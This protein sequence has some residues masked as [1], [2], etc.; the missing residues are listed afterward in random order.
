MAPEQLRPGQI[1]ARADQWAYCATLYEALYGRPPFRRDAAS[2]RDEVLSFPRDP[3]SSGVPERVL[4]VLKR[5][6]RVAPTSRFDSMDALLSALQPRGRGRWRPWAGA[7]AALFTGA[8]LTGYITS[9]PRPTS[10]ALCP[11]Q[12]ARVS[13]LWNNTRADELRARF[14]DAGLGYATQSATRVIER[15]DAYAAAWIAAER[16]ACLRRLSGAEGHARAQ[17]ACLEEHLETWAI[18]LEL[19]LRG[20]EAELATTVERAVSL[21]SSLPD[22][23]QCERPSARSPLARLAPERGRELARH[24]NR[25]KAHLR[26]RQLPAAALALERA[27]A[28]LPTNNAELDARVSLVEAELALL[29]AAPERALERLDRVIELASAER[30]LHLIAE[31]A[32]MQAEVKGALMADAAA[33]RDLLRVARISLATAAS[34]PSLRGQLALVQARVEYDSNHFEAGR[35]ATEAAIVAFEQAGERGHARLGESLQ[36]LSIMAFGA[37]DYAR[38]DALARRALDLQ[39]ALLGDDHPELAE[40]IQV[41]G[42]LELIAGR[43][44]EAAAHFERAAA[45]QRAHLGA[46]HPSYARTLVN[47]GNAYVESGDSTS[48]LAH[49]QRARAIFEHSLTPDDPRALSCLLNIG[50]ILRDLGD[51]AAAERAFREVIARSHERGDSSANNLTTA[52]ANLARALHDQGRAREAQAAYEEAL[53]LRESIFGPE[54]PKTAV[55]YDALGRFFIETGRPERGAPYIESGAAIRERR[56][57]REHPAFV[58]SQISRAMVQLARHQPSA[59]VET[60]ESALPSLDREGNGEARGHARWQL[61]RALLERAKPEELTRAA[62]LLTSSRELLK[63]TRYAS[64]LAAWCATRAD[65]SGCE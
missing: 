47:L 20:D 24:I 15:F 10:E 50:G 64:E 11:E 40:T 6:L 31:A 17:E 28:Q 58:R 29:Q 51:A 39:V 33:A 8:M 9:D 22:V 61:A 21:A 4:R 56:L 2:E 3:R 46:T 53:A 62:A 30:T 26:A 43:G 18:T 32:V 63:D 23:H 55:V 7:G 36:L 27:R 57:G 54:H 19:L 16:S 25:A 34:G 14:D 52:T 35:L 5:G 37:G 44:P 48:A 59:A 38:A 41:L 65:T 1:D 42:A 49:Y 60:L 13:A 12:R 45:L